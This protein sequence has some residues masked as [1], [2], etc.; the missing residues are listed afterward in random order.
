MFVA[1][2]KILVIKPEGPKNLTAASA[3]AESS[4]EV[5]GKKA[6]IRELTLR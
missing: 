1:N 4:K 5:F 3:V 2:Q 6:S